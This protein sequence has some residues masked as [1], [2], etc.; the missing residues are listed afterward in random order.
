MDSFC[1]EIQ[2]AENY[3]PVPVLP[4]M[5]VGSWGTRRLHEV[6]LATAAQMGDVKLHFSN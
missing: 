1:S 3:S 4:R 6:L 2:E 5:C